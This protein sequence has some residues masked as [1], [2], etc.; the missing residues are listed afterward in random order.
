M[1]G[2]ICAQ[3]PLHLAE[4]TGGEWGQKM[5]SKRVRPIVAARRLALELLSATTTW[6]PRFRSYDIESFLPFAA[7]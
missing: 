2:R 7:H 1:H 4:E 3:R 6:A 5:W